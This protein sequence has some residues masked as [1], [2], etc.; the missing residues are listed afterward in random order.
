MTVS[1]DERLEY[2][3]ELEQAT[4]MLNHPGESL[5]LQ[6]DFLYMVERVDICIDYL[7]SHVCPPYPAMCLCVDG[8]S[9]LSATLQRGGNIPPSLPTM[10][11]ARYDLDQDV[12]RRLVAC[13][14]HGRFQAT[15]GESERSL[16]PSP[17][18]I[19]LNGLSQ[20]VST[21]AQM[22]LLYT[23]FQTVSGPL[24]PLLAELE[25][26]AQAHPDELSALLAECH[27]AYFSARRSLLV[28]RLM[29]EIKGLDPA[30]TELVELVGIAGQCLSTCLSKLTLQARPEPAAATSSS[31]ARM[32]S[33]YSG[34]SSTLGKS[35]FSA[36][37]QCNRA[38]T[39]ECSQTRRL[40]PILGEPLRLS[41]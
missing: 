24:A 2:F 28:G 14:D 30:R 16:Q 18:V 34:H 4:R 25:R 3:Q 32:N 13:A 27:V 9:P 22:H 38:R 41:L 36:Y 19:T 33:I 20:D 29:E 17:C 35:S 6:T 8:G 7:K 26:R 40:Q 21:T 1:I 5:V 11:D 15:G 39:S 23:R 10:Y 12:L 31:C 37:P